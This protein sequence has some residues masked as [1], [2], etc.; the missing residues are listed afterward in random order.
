V[1]L[2]ED[3]FGR[4]HA[5]AFNAALLDHGMARSRI[6]M[7]RVQLA[8]VFVREAAEAPNCADG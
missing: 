7:V 2:Y 8:T 1:R 4:G 6:S 5:H 3:G